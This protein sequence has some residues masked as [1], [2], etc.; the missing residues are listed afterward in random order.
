[1][2]MS[3]AEFGEVGA[4]G[5]E[6][7]PGEV[8]LLAARPA[9]SDTGAATQTHPEQPATA[10]SLEALPAE[11]VRVTKRLLHRDKPDVVQVIDEESKLFR[12][13]VHSLEAKEA[14]ARFLK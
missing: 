3:S 10:M 6:D 5:A 4:Q 11:S 9:V 13:R 2:S 8:S 12:E 14:I 7:F 1:M